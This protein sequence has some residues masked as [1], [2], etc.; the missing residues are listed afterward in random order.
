M[1]DDDTRRT[2]PPEG[3]PADEPHKPLNET[4]DDVPEGQA[5]PE[6]EQPLPGGPPTAPADPPS[7][8]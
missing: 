2:P 3:E 4:P 6:S 1:P 5:E 8:G 7:A